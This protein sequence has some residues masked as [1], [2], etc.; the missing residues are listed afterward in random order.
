M[1]ESLP[2]LGA[3]EPSLLPGL[4]DS[5]SARSYAGASH[6]ESRV[7]RL[8]SVYRKVAFCLLSAGLGLATG[9]ASTASAVSLGEAELQSELFRPLDARLPLSLSGGERLEALN[10]R[11]NPANGAG[12]QV[13]ARL[14]G[15][16]TAPVVQLYTE[17]AMREPMVLLRVT[18]DVAGAAV[19]RDVTLLLD[20]PAGAANP[21]LSPT[22]ATGP[23]RATA[24]QT[25]QRI[26]ND[27]ALTRPSTSAPAPSS[28]SRQAAAR[29]QR[30][31]FT[32][33]TGASTVT[34][35]DGATLSEIAQALKPRYQ[36]PLWSIAAGLFAANPEAFGGSMDQLRA[37]SRLRLPARIDT[38]ADARAAGDQPLA[39][40]GNASRQSAPRI[41]RPVETFTLA[42][43]F[44]A[45]SASLGV[46]WCSGAHSR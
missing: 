44:R 29:A 46:A 26:P 6:H 35:P 43:G 10:I 37:G 25:A 14:G 45:V 36:M 32:I 18:V 23:T 9:V 5:L 19:S 12:E 41:E 40:A 15:S 28:I 4:G 3:H 42:A 20:M 16:Q 38:M 24:A 31:V 7:E 8:E 11:V 2:T 27:P 17:Q 39:P 22:S 34:V 21:P 30:E 33:S 13:R 1:R